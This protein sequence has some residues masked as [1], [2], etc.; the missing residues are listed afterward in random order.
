MC[1]I[2][3]LLPVFA[4][5]LFFFL[6][7]GQAALLSV[8][9]FLIFF[10]LAWVMWKDMRRPVST[11]NSQFGIVLGPRCSICRVDGPAEAEKISL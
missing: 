11:Y 3:F 6:P 10:W 9:L 8:P 7:P 4:V 2:L 1:H 5:V